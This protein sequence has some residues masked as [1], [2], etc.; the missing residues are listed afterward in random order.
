MITSNSSLINDT[1]IIGTSQASIA[2]VA[3]SSINN[4]FSIHPLNGVKLNK[5]SWALLPIIPKLIQ[6][7]HFLKFRKNRL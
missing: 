4:A 2:S 6:T 5:L 7:M 3:S 1:Y